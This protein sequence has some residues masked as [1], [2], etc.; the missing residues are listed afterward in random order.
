MLNIISLSLPFFSIILAGYLSKNLNLFNQD[1]GRKIAKF[2]FFIALPPFMFLNI[3]NSPIKD[4]LD[5]AEEIVDNKEYIQE[6]IE[7]Y[8]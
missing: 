5:L 8:E 6:V 2:A 1:D 4:I 3:I 7:D